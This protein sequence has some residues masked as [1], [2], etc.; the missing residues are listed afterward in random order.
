MSMLRIFETTLRS[1]S[2]SVAPASKCMHSLRQATSFFQTVV[3]LTLIC[4]VVLCF[5]HSDAKLEIGNAA[6][7]RLLVLNEHSPTLAILLPGLP[8]SDRSIEVLFPEHVT[9]VYH[10]SSKPRH[11]YLSGEHQQTPAVWRLD[12]TSVQYER[13]LEGG[14]HIL[15]RAE[16]QGEGIVFHYEFL[17]RSHNAYDMI[18]AA[19]DPRLTGI[20]HDERLQ[21][22]FVHHKD[23][24]DLL[25]SETPERLTLPLRQ[26]LPSRY[27]AS[28]TWP[29]PSKHVQKQE[30]GTTLYYKSRPVDVPLVATFS[31]DHKWVVASFAHSTGNVWS[32]PELTCQHV[33]PE[34]ALGPGQRATTEI[35]IVMSR[36]LNEVLDEIKARQPLLKP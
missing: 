26:W 8:D 30:D 3:P 19:T 9:G 27:L 18:Y 17:N 36:N 21:R 11:L 10:G 24:F 32:N 15:A 14:V 31:T 2:D 25:A 7:L 13:D 29:V 33:D 5:T 4:V 35:K 23:G 34:I 16:L 1:C 20:F 12:R 28:F 6:G 22:T